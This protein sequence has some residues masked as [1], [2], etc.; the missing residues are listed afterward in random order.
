M[1]AQVS[2]IFSIYD[3]DNDAVLSKAT[4]DL[5]VFL[6]G[7]ERSRWAFSKRFPSAF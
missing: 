5:E 1:V 2:L 7:S 3:H 6:E 4:S